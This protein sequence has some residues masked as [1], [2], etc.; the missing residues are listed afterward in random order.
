MDIERDR[1]KGE[2]KHRRGE[3]EER[4]KVFPPL[5]KGPLVYPIFERV[6]KERVGKRKI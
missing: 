4:K 5:N 6:S 2:E 1:K 3:G